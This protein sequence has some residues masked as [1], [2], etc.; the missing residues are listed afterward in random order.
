MDKAFNGVGALLIE[1]LGFPRD[2]ALLAPTEKDFKKVPCL[3]ENVLEYGNFGHNKSYKNNPGIKHGVEHLKR[4]VSQSKKFSGYSPKEVWS[5]VPYMFRW[6]GKKCT[7]M[8]KHIFR[9]K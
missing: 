7:R 8:V 6:W 9:K 1:Y 2:T 4:I 3:L 5:K